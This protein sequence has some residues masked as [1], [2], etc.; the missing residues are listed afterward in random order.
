MTADEPLTEDRPVAPAP[1]EPDSVGERPMGADEPTSAPAPAAR[2]RRVLRAVLRWTSAVLVFAALGGATAY[3]VTLPERAGIPGLETPADGR[4]TYPALKLPRL[5]EG[6][7]RALDTDRNTSG[8]HYAD[9]RGLLLPVPRGAKADNAFPGRGGWLPA[10]TF[11]KLFQPDDRRLLELEL[12]QEGLRHIAARAWTMPDGT[13]AETYLVQF[14]T[15]AY[16]TRFHGDLSTDQGTFED[17]PAVSLDKAYD[18]YALPVGINTY[19]YDEDRPRGR[20]HVRYA[21]IVAG[22]TI[23]VVV[24]SRAGSVPVVPFHQ[25]VDLQGELLG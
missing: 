14:I 9:A 12:E 19:V 7:P 5:P 24:L 15:K 2:E 1:A 10:A 4:W 17:A 22:D 8:R 21:Y 3:A 16:A 11:V 13:R 6:A 25:A 23:A 20:S 18:S